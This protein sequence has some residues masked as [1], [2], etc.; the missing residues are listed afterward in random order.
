MEYYVFKLFYDIEKQKQIKFRIFQCTAINHK[1]V[2]DKI[3][4]LSLVQVN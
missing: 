4:I 2:Y 3:L 1:F